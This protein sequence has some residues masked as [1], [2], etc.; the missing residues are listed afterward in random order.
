MVTVAVAG[1]VKTKPKAPCVNLLYRTLAAKK[2]KG[3][4]G[5]PVRAIFWL[6]KDCKR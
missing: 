6:P 3:I 5:I 4:F 1:T 2:S